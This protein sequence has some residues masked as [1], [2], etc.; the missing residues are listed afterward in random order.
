MAAQLELSLCATQMARQRPSFRPRTKWG[1][2]LSLKL[3]QDSSAL[4]KLI[5]RTSC[6][7]RIT[8]D[9]CACVA[10]LDGKCPAEAAQGTARGLLSRAWLE[11]PWNPSG[12]SP[13]Q[14]DRGMTDGEF[15]IFTH[16]GIQAHCVYILYC[17]FTFF[18]FCNVTAWPRCV[19][20]TGRLWFSGAGVLP[21]SRLQGAQTRTPIES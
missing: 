5:L 2:K 9:H 18:Y 21:L 12:M 6:R 15:G 19:L 1:S 16:P 20:R 17:F 8:S 14:M 7:Y 10:A 4:E 3:S 11:C 13:F